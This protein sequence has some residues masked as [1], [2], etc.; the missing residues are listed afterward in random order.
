MYCTVSQD[1]EWQGNKQR[2]QQ[3]SVIKVLFTTQTIRCCWFQWAPLF[4][5]LAQNITCFLRD[6][7]ATCNNVCTELCK[8]KSIPWSLIRWSDILWYSTWQCLNAVGSWH[9]YALILLIVKKQNIG[10]NIILH[11]YYNRS[12]CKC[13]KQWNVP[14]LEPNHVQVHSQTK[15]TS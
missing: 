6:S 9:K 3:C 8:G 12:I 11:V 5:S 1:N 2:H 14:E 7:S 4:F 15:K 10:S 13:V